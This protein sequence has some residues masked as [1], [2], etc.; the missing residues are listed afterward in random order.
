[1]NIWSNV[2]VPVASM[3]ITVFATVYT[4]RR[5]VENE[6]KEKHKPYLTLNDIET[7]DSVDEYKYYLTVDEKRDNKKTQENE[8]IP[9]ILL[10]SNIGYGVASNIK[11]YNL[12]TGKVIE[13]N[14]SLSTEKNQKLYITFDIAINAEKKV[15]MKILNSNKENSILCIYQDLNGHKYN[16][17]ININTKTNKTYDFYTFQ[18]TSKSYKKCIDKYKTQY[19]E[20]LKDYKKTV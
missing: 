1:M 20:I 5:R 17:I 12:A 13:G 18:R 3:I 8:Y 15:Q 2:L 9:V 6:N 19:K 14:Q 10:L 16:F 11:F 4:V 7:V